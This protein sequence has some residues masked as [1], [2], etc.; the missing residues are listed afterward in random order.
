MDTLCSIKN[1]QIVTDLYRKPSDRNKYLLPDSCHANSVKENIPFSLF[2]RITRI[3]SINQ[4]KEKRFEELKT[5]LLERNYPVR[6][7]DSA[8]TKARKITRDQA[9]KLVAKP[10]TT[11]RPVFVVTWDPRLPSIQAITNRHWRTMTMVDPQLQE[12]Y[13]EPPLIAYKCQKNIKDFLIRAN[14]PPSL[15]KNQKRI[16][17]GME[18]CIYKG[19]QCHTCPYVKETSEIKS[20]TFN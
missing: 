4:T 3:C 12:V 10:T 1:G 14:V 19:R 7:I 9:L 15:R 17:P 16:I 13:P 11:R 6:M 5:M 18:Q 2:L 8:M 20:N